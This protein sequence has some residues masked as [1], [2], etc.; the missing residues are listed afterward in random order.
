MFWDGALSSEFADSNEALTG[1]SVDG[2]LVRWKAM[3]A[4]SADTMSVC[5]SRFNHRLI[6]AQRPQP[7]L[8]T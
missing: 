7:L 5:N 1:R 3:R 6:R 4:R 8:T 2:V